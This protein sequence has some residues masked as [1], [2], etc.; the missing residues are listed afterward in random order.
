[1]SAKRTAS[2]ATKKLPKKKST[3]KRV[4][5]KTEKAWLAARK[6]RSELLKKIHVAELKNLDDT[7]ATN[8]AVALGVPR[9]LVQAKPTTIHKLA[10][11]GIKWH[12]QKSR[13][14]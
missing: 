1:M 2:G 11:L 6:K 14:K 7:T 5:T 8:Q 12:R 10:A 3:T 9:E 13:K 4:L